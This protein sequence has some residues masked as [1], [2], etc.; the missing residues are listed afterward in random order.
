MPQHKS[1]L[2]DP[3]DAWSWSRDRLMAWQLEQFNRQSA[4]I[5]PQNLFYAAKLKNAGLS[6]G[7]RL[8]ELSELQHWP[9]TTKS[10]LSESCQLSGSGISRHQ[11]YAAQDYSRVHRTSGTRGE[12][13][14][15]L[16]TATDWQWWS[17]T[18]QHV[19]QAANV[20]PRDR[21]FLAFSFGPF[22]GFWSAHQACVDRGAMVI[23][24]GG[25]STLARLE[26]M[27]QSAAN[28]VCCTPSY[29]LH[30]AEVAQVEKFPLAELRVDRLIVAGEAGGSV[31]EVRQRMA[32]L[33]RADVIDHAGATEIG[34]WGFGL[35]DRCG[36]YVAETSFIAEVIPLATSDATQ[37]SNLGELVLTSLGRLGAPVIRYRT[38]D[39]VRLSLDHK[40]TEC[41]FCWLPEGVIGRAD[42]MVTI[43]GVNIFPSSIDSLVR[44][45]P[46][47]GEYQVQVWREGQLDQLSLLVEATPEDAQLLEKQLSLKTGLRMDVQVV[48]AGS[49]PRSEAKSRRWMDRR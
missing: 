34:P 38:G 12:P 46:N 17:D 6:L 14:M 7:D 47:I 24:G 16:D 28:V 18:W 33:W 35:R 4:A 30:M 20:T 36:L 2:P 44:S 26:F 3:L 41:G 1:S 48:T 23:P 40:S 39:V 42:D 22:I 5:L 29:A 37:P 25:L 49:L 27:R 31:P 11:T 19:L 21:V 15:I 9:L 45:L 10:E 43:R 8:S 13:L 32:K